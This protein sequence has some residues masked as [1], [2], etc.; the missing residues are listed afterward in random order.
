MR[1]WRRRKSDDDDP[2]RP[3]SEQEKQFVEQDV[4]EQ[5]TYGVSAASA[6]PDAPVNADDV[7]GL[8]LPLTEGEREVAQREVDEQLGHDERPSA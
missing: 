7:T 6:P 3:L 8:D 5:S 2:F 1:L 4:R